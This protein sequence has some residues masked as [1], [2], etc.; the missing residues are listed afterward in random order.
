ML[1]LIGFRGIMQHQ[2]ARLSYLGRRVSA[3]R[4]AAAAAPPRPLLL[5]PLTLEFRVETQGPTAPPYNTRSCRGLAPLPLAPS[6]LAPT[7]QASTNL[8]SS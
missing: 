5:P 3:L 8:S 4:P 7:S 6:P 1:P 2:S